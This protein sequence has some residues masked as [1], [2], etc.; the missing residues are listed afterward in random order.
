MPSSSAASSRSGSMQSQ[1]GSSNVIQS[2]ADPNAAL[3]EAQ[4]MAVSADL[5]SREIFSLRSMQHKD[6]EGKII[7]D[8]DLSNPTRPR[9]ER[10][11]DTIR[12]FE[13]AIESTRKQNRI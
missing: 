8:P 11:L 13:A 5:G 10:P 9:L 4:P 3:F 1:E 6:R 12:G 7:T 2:K